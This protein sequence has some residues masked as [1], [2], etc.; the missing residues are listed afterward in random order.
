MPSKSLIASLASLTAIAAGSLLLGCEPCSGMG[1]CFGKPHVAVSG[2]LRDETTGA[3]VSGARMD[4]V[5]VGGVALFHDSVRAIT[6]AHGNFL[7]SV[8]AL[9]SGKVAAQIAI[10]GPDRSGSPAFAYRVYDLSLSTLDVVGDARVFLPWSTRPSQPDLAQIVRAGVPVGN[11]TI[12]F[13]RTGGVRLAGGDLF[14]TG[15]DQQGMCEL[16]HFM[17]QPLDAGDIVGD[18]YINGKLELRGL[19]LPVTPSFRPEVILRT[20]DVAAP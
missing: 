2:V 1:P 3:P 5:R 11:S 19:R 9:D 17:A 18:I 10:R 20:I 6:D 14:Q 13:Q 4:L 16:F 7:L 8:D 12:G 15:T